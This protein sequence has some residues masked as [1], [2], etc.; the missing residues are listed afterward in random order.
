MNEGVSAITRL[1]RFKEKK[2]LDPRKSFNVEYTQ[3]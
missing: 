3:I 2:M 1:V